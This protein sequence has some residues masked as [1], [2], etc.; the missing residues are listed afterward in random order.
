[1]TAGKS[2]YLSTSITL[3]RDS[4][5]NIAVDRGRSGVEMVANWRALGFSAKT[6]SVS[7]SVDNRA[8]G[9]VTIQADYIVANTAKFVTDVGKP[10]L[11]ASYVANNTS[12][13]T[14][15]GS[16]HL[17]YT[18]QSATA[19]TTST[20]YVSTATQCYAYF[21]TGPSGYAEVSVYGYLDNDNASG[22]TYLS[23]DIAP[24]DDLA[25]PVVAASDNRA[26]INFGTPQGAA[27]TFYL[28]TGLPNT[29]YKIKT[30]QRAST[31]TAV[32]YTRSV[33]VIP[34]T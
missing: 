15:G 2:T 28:F 13:S 8:R 19:N 6:A 21:T 34:I 12:D 1:L 7:A 29:R 14:N 22:I 3:E 31:G 18:I 11:N 10:S 24:A 17:A 27:S 23:F 20:T 9:L 4:Y 32:L 5:I 30:M 33:M 25:N 26:V 16:N